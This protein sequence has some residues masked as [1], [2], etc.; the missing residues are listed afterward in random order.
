MVRSKNWYAINHRN[1]SYKEHRVRILEKELSDMEINKEGLE[2]FKGMSELANEVY[3]T[4]GRG[5]PERVYHTY[6]TKKLEEKYTSVVQEQKQV[7]MVNGTPCG[8]IIPD[9]LASNSNGDYVIEVKI[10]N[11]NRGFLQLGQYVLNNPGRIGFLVCYAVTGVEMYMILAISES[12]CVCY[13]GKGIYSLNLN[14]KRDI[15]E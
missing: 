15:S 14:A 1:R 10:N 12:E 11:L 9:I 2:E 8:A 5:L 7:Y 6:M 4:C 13:D 3:D